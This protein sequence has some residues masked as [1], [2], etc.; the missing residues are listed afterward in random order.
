VSTLNRLAQDLSY[1]SGPPSWTHVVCPERGRGCPNDDWTTFYEEGT[2]K[3]CGQHGL[4]RVCMVPCK[5]C[6]RK[7]GTHVRPARK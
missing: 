1:K 7:P 6:R 2:V 3:Q 5:E 4:P